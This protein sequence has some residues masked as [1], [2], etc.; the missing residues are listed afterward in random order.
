MTKQKST[1][2]INFRS[3]DFF[4]IYV[5]RPRLTFSRENLFL[6]FRNQLEDSKYL[7]L[8]VKRGQMRAS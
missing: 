5:G 6:I 4:Q 7:V 2:R 3:G 1:I 8:R